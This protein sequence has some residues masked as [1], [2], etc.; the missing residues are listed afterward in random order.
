MARDGLPALLRAGALVGVFT[1]PLC[2]VL[3]AAP[4]DAKDA[5]HDTLAA[6]TALQHGR[7]L[8]ARGNF[9][10]AVYVLEG[11]L[12]KANGSKE[13]LAALREAYRGH[14]KELR[15]ANQTAQAE[16]YFRRLL[17]LDPG[18]VLDSAVAPAAKADPPKAEPVVRAK[19][20]D[21]PARK[22]DP[23]SPDNSK[24]YKD[25][26]ALAEKAEQEF[27]ARHYDAAGRLFEQAHQAD[28]SAVGDVDRRGRWGYCKLY[29]VVQQLNQ[30]KH[31]T[32]YP[33]L[34]QQVRLAV[35]LAPRLES[36]GKD[37]LRRIQDRQ[38][39]AGAEAVVV[40]HGTADG[41][42]VAETTNFRVFHNQSRELA[43][44][45]AQVAERTR[46]DVHRKW[47]SEPADTWGLKCDLYLHATGA[48]YS[49]ATGVPAGS[50][51][52]STLRSE[53]PRMLV[54]RIDL[55]CDNPDM[56]TAVLP[57]EATHVV[58]AGKFGEQPLPRWADEGMAVLT[59]PREKIERHLRTLSQHRQERQ[60]FALR[61]LMEQTY[62]Q[63][64]QDQYPDP[65]RI[66]PFYAQS[67][68]L[69]EYLASLKGPQVFSQFLRDG[70]RSG[71]EAALRRH[72]GLQSFGEL[73]QQ[74]QG[75][76]FR[77]SLSA[78]GLAQQSR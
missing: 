68:S 24:A 18:A 50:P 11:Q 9:Q 58:L 4:P 36:F 42:Q 61:E 72:Y 57:H 69:V 29:D 62:Y 8:V 77:D 78:G 44:K 21:A 19:G 59:E 26:L 71:Y 49:R 55:H 3:G 38:A 46:A 28:K 15:L 67:V 31:T 5:V 47:F 53:G 35:G 16:V 37:L 60:L 51:G 12:T 65:R 43:E 64:R 54:R 22:A 41:W 25:A 75:Y 48:D 23:F 56:L 45:A 66:G 76:A 70:M 39:G 27:A 74:W 34:E 2:P 17:I 40:R 1:A 33:D 7:D 6:Q 30:P 32:S 10:E 73:E 14:V 63:P 52:H 13:Y 20:E